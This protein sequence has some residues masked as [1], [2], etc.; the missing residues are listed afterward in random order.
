MAVLRRRSA[1]RMPPVTAAGYLNGTVALTDDVLGQAELMGRHH[2]RASALRSGL[3]GFRFPPE[4]IMVAARWYLRY[5]LS[6]WDVEELLAERV[7]R[8]IT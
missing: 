1:I 6:Y 4:V 3:A 7:P 5:G 8:L 2:H